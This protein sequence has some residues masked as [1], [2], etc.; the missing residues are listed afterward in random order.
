MESHHH[1]RAGYRYALLSAIGLAAQLTFNDA[2]DDI[3]DREIQFTQQWESWAKDHRDYLKEGDRLFDRTFHFNDILDGNPDAL[4]GY[5]HIRGDRGYVFLENPGPVEQIAELTLALDAPASTAFSVEEIYPGGMTLEGPAEGAYPQGGKLRVTVPAK[6]VRILWITP[7]SP[8]VRPGNV[9]PE[10]ARAAQWKRYV[11]D[12]SVSRRD[13]DTVTVRATFNY[14]LSARSYLSSTVQEAAWAKEPWNFDKAYLV[15]LLKDET[16]TAHD[17]WV[18]DDFARSI[19]KQGPGSLAG[20]LQNF[21]QA[22]TLT[23][24]LNGVA[25]PPQPFKTARI[26]SEGLTRCYFVALEGETKPGES[27]AVEVTLPIQRGLVFA[28][29][30]L[31]L[32]DQVPLG[33][34]PRE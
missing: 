14:P 24:R 9:Q 33:E 10:D 1:D 8:D 23:V 11:G 25:K 29:A 20:E 21:Y 4:D 12:W 22:G 6:Q 28:G 30:Y 34:P 19:S 13:T 26:Q 31:D 7:A 15:L 16:V 5:A 32:P 27:N 3:P 2:P 17:N 18:P